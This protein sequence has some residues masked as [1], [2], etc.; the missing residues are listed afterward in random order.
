MRDPGLPSLAGRYL[1]GDNC[2]SGLESVVLGAPGAPLDTGLSVA[3]LTSFGE[4]A[5][6]RIYTAS[7][8]GGVSRLQDGAPSPCSFPPEPGAPG[9]PG[10]PAPGSAADTR[11][12]TLRVA[13]RGTQRFRRLRLALRADED[14]TATLRAR[15][16]RTRRVALKAGVRRTVR[17]RATRRGARR[18]RRALARRGRVRQTIRIAAR[19]AAGNVERRRA[20]L[21]LRR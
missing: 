17:I 5:C 4:D 11:A 13:Y 2:H 1:Y 9:S 15:R 3:A 21:N 16:F 20:R 12:P 10:G 8:D 19:D 14:C 6:G 7:L 18:I